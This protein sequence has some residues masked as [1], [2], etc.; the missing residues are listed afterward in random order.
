MLFRSEKIL[1]LLDEKNIG[2][3]TSVSSL[4]LGILLSVGLSVH[5]A[6][7]FAEDLW[8]TRVD[9]AAPGSMCGAW[10]Y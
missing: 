3:L 1:V 2:V 10:F 9:C 7:G 4:V 5:S 6:L 8:R